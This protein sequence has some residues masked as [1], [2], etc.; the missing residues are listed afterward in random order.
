[1]KQLPK[2]MKEIKERINPFLFYRK[3]WKIKDINIDGVV[4]LAPMAGVTNVAYRNFAKD[5]HVAAS[6]SEMV[7]DCGL[8]YNNQETYRYLANTDK[9]HPF[10]VQLFGGSK[11]TLLK[12]LE[13]LENGLYDYD[14]IDI[15]LGCPVMKVTKTGAGSSWL[16]R[17]QELYEMMHA[18]VE[19]SHKPI[20]AKIRLGWDDT[21]INFKE[22][23]E[24]LEKAGVAMIAIHSR[25]RKDLYSGKA[26]HELL[27]DLQLQMHVPL[28]ISGDIFSL[29]DAIIAQEITKASAI[30]VARG[31][32]GNPFLITQIDH[33]FKTKE[34]L[35]NPTLK[36]NL[37][38]LKEHYKQLKQL[39]GENIAVREM[40]GLAPHYLKSYPNMKKW[41]NLLASTITTE[42][43]LFDILQR[44]E[45]TI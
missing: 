20:T 13:I 11:D 32:L 42:K 39:K 21:S 33:Y 9:D 7:S 28:V 1:M 23:V 10:G 16:K 27:K 18:L 12:A 25:T 37:E 30:M 40:R 26:R 45:E 36:E 43:D 41:R 29:E 15:N 2:A 3:M 4:V 38:Y 24:L 17:P 14:F 5:F 8:I 6:V 19:H 44:I 35:P 22:I 34:K 31:A